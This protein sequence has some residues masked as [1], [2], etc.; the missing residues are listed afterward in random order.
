MCEKS[1]IINPFILS[2]F[3]YLKSL[4]KFISYIGGVWLVFIMTCFVGISELNANSIDLDQ[5]PHSVMSDLGLHCLPMSLLWGAS[6]KWV[7]HLSCRVKIQQM[8]L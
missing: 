1:S 4:D 3:F 2:G 8:T 5:K 7:K 6:L